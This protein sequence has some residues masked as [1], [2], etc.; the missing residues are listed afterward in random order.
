MK[1]EH[2][3]ISLNSPNGQLISEKATIESIYTYIFDQYPSLM[4]QYFLWV[5][6]LQLAFI[7]SCE[8][9]P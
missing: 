4:Q 7:V 2:F 3:N 6:F 5:R 1:Y 9:E 8:G